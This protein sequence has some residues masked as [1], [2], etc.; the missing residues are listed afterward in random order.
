[1]AEIPNVPVEPSDE[2]FEIRFPECER[3]PYEQVFYNPNGKLRGSVADSFYTVARHTVEQIAKHEALEDLVGVAAL[4]LYR[5]YLELTLKS[6]VRSLRRLETEQ[7][8]RPEEDRRAVKAKHPLTQFWNEI[9]GDCPQKVGDKVWRAWDTKLA[10]NCIAVFDEIDPNGERFRYHIENGYGVLLWEKDGIVGLRCPNLHKF[11]TQKTQTD[12][13][14]EVF[15]CMQC[16]EEEE[17]KAKERGRN[18]DQE[19][20]G[21]FRVRDRLNPLA[22]S[23]TALLSVM[24]Q[25]HK[26]LEA[27]DSYLVETYFQNEEWEEEQNSW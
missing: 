21:K 16:S 12:F 1:M 6:I 11:R 14:N 25:A 23:W 22:V 26:V 15:R 18:F 2:D 10:G 9:K 27:I 13:A 24:D 3:V 20:A 8:N 4:Y 17:R 7:Q 19:N 5:H